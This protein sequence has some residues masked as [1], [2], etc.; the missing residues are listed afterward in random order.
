MTRTGRA[1]A[2]Q[3]VWRPAAPDADAAPGPGGCQW[4]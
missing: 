1:S 3:A 2:G 4:V